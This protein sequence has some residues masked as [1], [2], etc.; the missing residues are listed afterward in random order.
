MLGYIHLKLS[1]KAQSVFLLLLALVLNTSQTFSR[2]IFLLDSFIPPLT[3]TCFKSLQSVQS[4]LADLLLHTTAL[5][6]G[7]TNSQTTSG[8]LLPA[9]PPLNSSPQL[10]PATLSKLN[11]IISMICPPPPPSFQCWGEGVQA[12]DTSAVAH[13]CLSMCACSSDIYLLYKCQLCVS[14]NYYCT[15]KLPL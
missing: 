2:F 10:L 5:Q 11:F 13:V 6:S 12:T 14:S 9:T 1:S 4:Q 15:F 8:T 7:T 3:L